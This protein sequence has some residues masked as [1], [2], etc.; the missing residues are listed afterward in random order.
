M[1]MHQQTLNWT[2]KAY[3]LLVRVKGSGKYQPENT[4]ESCQPVE[5][6]AVAL[7][8]LHHARPRWQLVAWVEAQQIVQSSAEFKNREI[9]HAVC[10]FILLSIPDHL[11]MVVSSSMT[12]IDDFEDQYETLKHFET[13]KNDFVEVCI[14]GLVPLRR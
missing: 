10:I 3:C 6:D 2:I 14:F 8:G 9:V 7:E 13:R 4:S 1:N 5:A 12:S 11:D